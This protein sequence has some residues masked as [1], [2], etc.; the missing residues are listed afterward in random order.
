MKL[1]LLRSAPAA[2]LLLALG[3]APALADTIYMVDGS[4]LT[5][6]E[7]VKEQF[8]G[9]TYKS[10]GKS[11][12]DRVDADK[13]LLIEYRRLPRQIDE[14]ETL[15]GDGAILDGIDTL[16][17]FVEDVLSGKNRRDRQPWA[18]GYALDRILHLRM[19]IGDL[20][21]VVRAADR[22]VEKVPDSR[23]APSALLDKAQAQRMQGK[24]PA[25]QATLDTL[26]EM[27]AAKGLSKRWSL[28]LELAEVLGNTG[29]KGQAKRD[30]LI[31]VAGQAGT[32]WPMVR[33][34]ARVAEGETWLE[35][36]KPDYQKALKIFEDIVADPKADH[37]TLAGAYTGL[38]DCLFN[39][40]A[41]EIRGGG[42][43]DDELLEALLAY[44]RVV[45][46][47]DD[48]PGY[49]PKAMFYAGRV[50]DYLGDDVSKSNARRLYTAVIRDYPRSDWAAEARNY[51]K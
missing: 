39:T 40:A 18:P 24:G 27:I 8:D 29:L 22:L 11:G 9:V 5:D 47:Y 32:A 33:S 34:R 1:R 10:K 30:R 46:N 12:E 23:H 4:T 31:E 7:V 19:G 48:Q 43:A 15:I 25:A 2:A 6:V 49:V 37:A 13:V 20:D 16:S 42:Q 36:D 3:A 44:M 51:R 26:R 35:G 21:G 45:V 17:Q 14:A 28:E 41:E 38:G 50:F